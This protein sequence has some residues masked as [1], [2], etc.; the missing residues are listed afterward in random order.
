MLGHARIVIPLAGLLLAT[1]TFVGCDNKPKQTAQAA[2][3]PPPT[4]D[5]SRNAAPV[6]LALYDRIGKDFLGSV[7][8][9]DRSKPPADAAA[10]KAHKADIDDLIAAT[11]LPDCDFG[12][13]V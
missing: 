6:Y 10:L 9:W 3:T 2:E 11:R 5:T 4:P 1:P 7:D 12:V 8:P 13:N